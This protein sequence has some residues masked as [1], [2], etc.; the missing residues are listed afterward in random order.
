MT[1]CSVV[2]VL[3]LDG[4]AKKPSG[5]YLENFIPQIIKY[6]CRVYK[7]KILGQHL[8]WGSLRTDTFLRITVNLDF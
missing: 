1:Y 4:L 7:L 5:Q 3:A 6:H 8:K 2:A